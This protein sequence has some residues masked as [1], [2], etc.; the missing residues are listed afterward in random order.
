LLP[1]NLLR[2]RT[3]KGQITPIY[4]DMNKENIDFARVLITLFKTHPGK[5]KGELIENVSA[6]EPR[7]YD[8]RL[9]R[10]LSQ[11]L[12]RQCTF[13]IEAPINPVLARKMIF[14]E[15]NRRNVTTEIIR[16]QIFIDVAN[17]LNV[18]T[19]QLEKAIYAD[20]DEELI[21]ADFNLI[22]EVELLKRYNLALTQT[23]LFRSTFLEIKVS[24]Y[25]KEI[26]REVKFR[27]LMYSA[28]SKEGK[29][30]ITVDGPLSLFKLT[31]RYGTSMAKMLP[32]IIQSKEW[33]INSSIIR[34]GQYGRR[35]YQLRLTSAQI[36][37]KIKPAYLNREDGQVFFDSFVEAK[38]Y[39]DFQSLGTGWKLTREPA[40]L[41]AGRH[42]FLPDFCF[43][44]RGVKLYLEIVGF[45]TRKY[46]ETKIKKLQQLKGVDILIAAD[47][48][49][50][51]DRLK[52]VP[53]EIIFYKKTVPIREF[54]RLLK[55]HEKVL[56]ESEVQS[57][58]LK[59]LHLE[60][61]IV[62]L[63]TIAQKYGVSVEALRVRLKD[64]DVDDYT[65]AG[66]I[67]I[68][69]EKLQ[70]IKLRLTLLA[71]PSLSKAIHAIEDEGAMKPYDILSALN[72]G[73]RW[74]GLNLENSLIYRKEKQKT[75]SSQISDK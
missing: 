7:G 35:I 64:I 69:N 49:L 29:F 15:A 22:N 9:V 3:K 37:D 2:V 43:E 55:K 72:Y 33:E 51:C 12:Q 42:V 65:L 59:N 14:E 46:L 73:I 4:T 26:L 54:L 32:T 39:E 61:D 56:L 25:W 28:E 44:K 6:Y 50:M 52:Q 16:A 70:E 36:G 48:K 24:D 27:G 18:T 45:W 66:E 62:E 17:Q 31:Q 74:N 21:L 10:G 23:L 68:K 13:K 34:T 11:I 1:L 8:Y 40:P 57:L 71:D 63:H 20:L 5:R 75:P 41:L 19:T 53:G 38:F 60:G 58:D 67:F 30:K 47:Q